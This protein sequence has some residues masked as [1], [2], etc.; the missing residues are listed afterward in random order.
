MKH[1]E[2]RILIIGASGQ[3]GSDL[4]QELRKQYGTDKVIASDLRAGSH[5]E[6][7]NPFEILDVLDVVRLTQ[8]VQKYEITEIY[9]LAAIL[10]ATGEKIPVKAWNINMEGLLNVLNVAKNNGVSKLF[11]PS[12][13]AV[14]GPTTPMDNTPQRTIME[15]NTVYGISKQAGERWVEYYAEKY[16]MDIRSIRY[17]GLISYATEPG[18]GTTDYAVDIYI[19]ALKHGKYECYLSPNTSLPM[20]YM[21]DAI[22]ATLQLM[23]SP[24]ENIKVKSSYNVSALSFTPEEIATSIRKFI[25]EFE[26]SYKSD[27]RQAL[28]D[29]WPNSIND[30]DARSDW[31]W[32]PDYNLDQMSENMIMNLRKQL[33]IREASL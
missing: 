29:S 32:S 23:D 27:F 15:P 24:E 30:D 5:S 3:I 1:G 21:P 17:P 16:Q 13:I 4:T 20:M 9:H 7:N 11:W 19:Q 26:I 8:V 28:A 14:F 33:K 25:P 18:G 10:S 12:S 22:K 2:K 6:S 31:N